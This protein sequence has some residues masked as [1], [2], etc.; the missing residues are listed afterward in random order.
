[1]HEI[2]LAIF[3]SI[4]FFLEALLLFLACNKPKSK[5]FSF[6]TCFKIKLATPCLHSK[7][8]SHPPPPPHPQKKINKKIIVLLLFPFVI[9][10]L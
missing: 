8:H 10:S 1:M 5:Q 3:L 9:P 2:F 6:V 7:P 4:L